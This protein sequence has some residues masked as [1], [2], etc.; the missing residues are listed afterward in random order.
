ILVIALIVIGP[1]KLPD[2]ARALGKGMSEFKKATQEIKESLD[3]D[4]ELKEAKEDLVDSISGL[5]KPLELETPPLP[6]EKEPKYKDFDDMLEVYGKSQ[7]D[8]P[9]EE[10]AGDGSEGGEK[11]QDG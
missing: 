6:E 2:L 9:K 1:S 10:K 11:N 3:V 7:E 8:T 5:D 4:Q